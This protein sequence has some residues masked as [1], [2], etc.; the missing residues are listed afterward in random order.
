[1][2]F[3][4]LVSINVSGHFLK[5][6]GIAGCTCGLGK[7]DETVKASKEMKD[8]TWSRGRGES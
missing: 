6:M 7:G 5:K 1:M 4:N 8:S 2:Y 3:L